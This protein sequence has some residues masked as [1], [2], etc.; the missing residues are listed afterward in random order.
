MTEKTKPNPKLYYQVEVGVDQ[1]ELMEQVNEKLKEG[2]Q[3]QGGVAMVTMPGE[4]FGEQDWL[5]AQ[6]LVLNR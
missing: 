1:F 5:F 3:L 2:W 4:T 6:A